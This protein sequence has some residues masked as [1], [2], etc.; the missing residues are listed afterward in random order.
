MLEAWAFEY[1]ET[2]VNENVQ[3]SPFSYITVMYENYMPSWR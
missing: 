2:H 1:S 3:A